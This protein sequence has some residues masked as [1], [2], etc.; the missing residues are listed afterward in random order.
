MITVRI[1]RHSTSQLNRRKTTRRGNSISPY[2]ADAF[3][4]FRSIS[5]LRFAGLSSSIDLQFLRFTPRNR[6]ALLRFDSLHVHSVRKEKRSRLFEPRTPFS[7]RMNVT[8]CCPNWTGSNCDQG[9]AFWEEIRS[10]SLSSFFFQL[11]RPTT[12]WSRTTTNRCH[13]P[14]AFFGVYFTIEPST[15]HCSISPV[16]AITNSVERNRGKSTFSRFRV[17]VGKNV[18]NNCRCCSD[19]STSRHK[20]RRS[21]STE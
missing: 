11:P 1:H 21:S 10:S 3:R 14:R 19:R 6:T 20:A 7:R 8:K 5:S 4:S 12:R 18:R 2:V 9:K 15:E 16:L 13:S 17:R